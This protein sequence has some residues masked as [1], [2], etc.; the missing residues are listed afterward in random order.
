MSEVPLYR[1]SRKRWDQST[2]EGKVGFFPLH[3][4]FPKN[5]LHLCPARSFGQHTCVQHPVLVSVC[6]HHSVSVS[7]WCVQHP[8]SVRT[9]VHHNLTASTRASNTPFRSACV[10]N[11]SLSLENGRHPI[12]K[13]EMFYN[14]NC[15]NISTDVSKKQRS[16]ENIKMNHPV[17]LLAS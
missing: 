8:F 1:A 5:P 6:I 12:S 11:T 15:K 9:C 14:C 3:L 7:T 17:R 16:V 10:S 4:H 2:C 13:L